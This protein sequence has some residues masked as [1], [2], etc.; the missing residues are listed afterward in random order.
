VYT[1]ASGSSG[2]AG[3]LTIPSAIMPNYGP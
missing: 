2:V 1:A 3:T